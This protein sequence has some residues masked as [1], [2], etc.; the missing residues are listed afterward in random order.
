MA[1][2]TEFE[3]A[4]CRRVGALEI[5]MEALLQELDCEGA[6]VTDESELYHFL[7]MFMDNS[8][9]EEVLENLR[10][11]LGVE[12]MDECELM[13]DIAQRLKDKENKE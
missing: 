5:E 7:D 11:K 3:M 10:N 9:R 8:E 2:R 1:K 4:K 6:L 12:I 13:V